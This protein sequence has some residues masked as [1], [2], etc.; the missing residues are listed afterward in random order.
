MSLQHLKNI[1]EDCIN[2]LKNTEQCSVLFEP[3][4]DLQSYINGLEVD[5]AS[6]E[7]LLQTVSLLYQ[8]KNRRRNIDQRTKEV[9]ERVFEQKQYLSK[10]ERE[11]VARRCNLT[12]IQ[13]RTWVCYFPVLFINYESTY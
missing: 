9:L 7:T 12:P 5:T 2:I 8:A 6:K 3:C 13:V 10:E 1:R 11:L 4:E